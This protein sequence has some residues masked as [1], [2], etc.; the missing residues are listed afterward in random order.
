[1]EPC[2]NLEDKLDLRASDSLPFKSLCTV[3]L[4]EYKGEA[5]Q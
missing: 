2:H 1:M 4:Q 3:Y 5:F